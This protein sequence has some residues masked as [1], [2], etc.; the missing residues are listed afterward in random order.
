MQTRLML[1][2][3][4]EELAHKLSI[5][6]DEYGIRN[7][8]VLIDEKQYHPEEGENSYTN[9]AELMLS[10][11]YPE[12][13][14]IVADKKNAGNFMKPL[15]TEK[16][17]PDNFLDDGNESHTVIFMPLHHNGRQFGYC[18][19]EDKISAIKNGSLYYWLSV[20]NTA[21]DTIRQNMCIRELNRR[22]EHLYMYDVLTGIYNRF[23]LQN[24]GAVLLNKNRKEGKKTLFLFA[25]MDGLK[26]INDTYG[27][28]AGD[29]AIKAMAEVLNDVHPNA[30]F[31][32]LRYGG[33]EFLM[34]GSCKDEEEAEH[35]K[36]QVELK[37]KEYS[38]EPK[39][40]EPLSA[41]IG[42]VLASEDEKELGMDDYIK[43]ADSMMYR[44]KQEKKRGRLV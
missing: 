18:A 33:D 6:L 10:G 35:V 28:E 27:H 2:Q 5:E 8:C 11:E 4:F 21:L 30:S 7:F 3:D 24:L 29:A 42:Y 9:T 13:M 39:I 14:S 41:S 19:M 34:M 15:A 32:C 23:A 22:L 44:I 17:I 38:F 40:P 43:Q 36:E 20:L 37:M 26:K 1:C 16:L 31:F 25:D 12:V